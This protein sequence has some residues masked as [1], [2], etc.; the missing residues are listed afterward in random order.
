MDYYYSLLNSYELLKRRKFKL[1]LREEEGEGDAAKVIK[2]TGDGK[3]HDDPGTL[4][5]VAV[6]IQNFRAGGGAEEPAEEPAE[7]KEITYIGSYEAGGQAVTLMKGVQVDPSDN[8]LAQKLITKLM[9]GEVDVGG[10]EEVVQVSPEQKELNAAAARMDVALH[11]NEEV[12][13]LLD[14]EGGSDMLPGYEP[15]QRTSRIEASLKLI[16][17]KAAGKSKEG[18]GVM[19]GAAKEDT[20]ITEKVISS[21][22]LDAGEAAKGV[23]AAV[24]TIALVRKIRAGTATPEELKKAS[25]QLEVT[26]EGILFNGI[27]MQYRSSSTGKNDPYRN[28]ADQVDTAIVKH[29]KGCPKEGAGANGDAAK[30]CR[31]KPLKDENIGRTLSKRGPMLEHATV[32]ILLGE[33]YVDC[34][35]SGD[36]CSDIE[37][38]ITQ[39]FEK[40]QGDGS[41]EEVEAMLKTGLCTLGN[42]CLANIDGADDAVI[43]QQVLEYLT[44][45]DIEG[46]PIE[47]YEGPGL[48]LDI[49]TALVMRADGTRGLAMLVASSRGFTGYLDTLKPVDATVWGGSGADL[50]GQKDDIRITIPEE[51]LEEFIKE[52]E[53]NMTGIEKELEEA[54]ECGGE[55][56]GLTAL[57]NSI[58]QTKL[59]DPISEAK[60][61]KKKAPQP[62]IKQGEGEITIGL[63]LKSRTSAVS[64][65][66]KAGEGTNKK[67]LEMCNPKEGEEGK[68]VDVQAEEK[69]AL[70]KE[71]RDKNNDRLNECQGKQTYNKEGQP[72]QTAE[73]AACAFANEVESTP[74]MVSFRALSAGNP[75]LDEDDNPQDGAGEALVDEWFESKTPPDADDK[76]R[77][78]LAKSAF[79]KLGKGTPLS[80]KER[81]AMSKVGYELE[82]AEIRGLLDAET[83]DE[84]IV[85][86]QALGYLL[87]RHAEDSGSLDEC[88]K[89]VRGYGDNTQKTGLI[90][91]TVYGSIAMVNTGQASVRRKKK[92]NSYTIETNGKEG[93]EGE[94]G[95]EGVALMKGSFERGQLVTEM[96]PDSM[97]DTQLRRNTKA[98]SSTAESI[99]YEFLQG[100]KALLEKLLTQS[101]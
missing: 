24:E 61:S 22:T 36:D 93:K 23:E 77:R 20:T 89:D 80:K 29:N 2:D 4:N 101:T 98:H 67:L 55:G 83:D 38:K 62:T 71:F 73:S 76:E 95:K 13:G 42:K 85:T 6:W 15:T 92:S 40:M 32:L 49:A 51:N 88:L 84:D 91:S 3:S 34:E 33:T 87:Y 53:D 78:D 25:D 8:E 72:Q 19:S 31:I 30:E 56:I 10:G 44:G 41:I 69:A 16:Q 1:S 50:K 74:N 90:N 47:G 58:T 27:Y 21:P 37:A 14:E 97:A 5:G 96:E 43:T 64:G 39:Q 45:E 66:T 57:G 60:K 68:E 81:E 46:Q 11:G 18:E 75:V 28:L 54:A 86:G 79:A 100:Q 94:E 17:A 59:T 9:G 48:D 65:R 82:Q 7:G 99:M 52:L 70:E 63:E 26:R 12:E 35:K